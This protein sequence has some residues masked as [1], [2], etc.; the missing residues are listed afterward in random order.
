MPRAKLRATSHD[1]CLG[2]PPVGQRGPAG[3]PGPTGSPDHSSSPEYTPLSSGNR[4]LNDLLP[5]IRGSLKKLISGLVCLPLRQGLY[6]LVSLNP[7]Q[8][9]EG[10]AHGGLHRRPV[11]GLTDYPYFEYPAGKGS[12]SSLRTR[13]DPHCFL[14]F[15]RLKGK[16]RK[17][18]GND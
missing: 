6:L 1:I 11:G 9:A 18:I 16:R 3:L 13:K 14:P 12:G 7:W 10:W 2:G 4:A 5:D 17:G 8:R 15:K